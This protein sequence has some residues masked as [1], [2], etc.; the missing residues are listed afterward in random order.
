MVLGCF[1]SGVCRKEVSEVNFQPSPPAP[2]RAGGASGFGLCFFFPFAV[3]NVLSE[4]RA[5]GSFAAP[6]PSE[7]VR[8]A[9]FYVGDVFSYATRDGTTNPCTVSLV[10]LKQSPLG[11]GQ[12]KR[13]EKGKIQ[14]TQKL[15]RYICRTT[16]LFIW[17]FFYKNTSILVTAPA[18][19]CTL[20]GSSFC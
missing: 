10:A 2:L 13:R 17:D 15:Q 1:W 14:R 11:V 18:I 16:S 12:A 6:S 5:E 9:L 8:E 7:T 3:P 20:I 19:N 4:G